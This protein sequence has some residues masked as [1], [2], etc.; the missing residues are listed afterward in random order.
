MI[1]LDTTVLSALMQRQPDPQIVAWLD[2][3][4]AESIWLSTITVFEA[5]YG[6]ALLADG[7]R[8]RLLQERLDGLLREDLEN[9]LLP[10]DASA[11]AQAATL[12]A[13]RKARGRAVDMRD[14]FIAGIAMA[15]R[16]AIATRNTGHFEGLT[17][18]VVNPWLVMSGGAA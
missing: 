10:F 18:P 8:K 9:R 14:T 4:A 3:Q 17:V 2:A 13:D 7:Q 1:L 16:A 5:R 15:R 6:L 11:A 12:A